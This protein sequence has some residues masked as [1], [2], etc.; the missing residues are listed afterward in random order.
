MKLAGIY[1]ATNG[2]NQSVYFHYDY[3]NESRAER[4]GATSSCS[5]S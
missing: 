1:E 4:P 3:L 2:D 5:S